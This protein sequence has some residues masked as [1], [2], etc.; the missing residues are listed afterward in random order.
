M[1]FTQASAKAGFIQMLKHLWKFF[2]SIPCWIKSQEPQGIGTLLVGIA[3]LWAL[4][5]G[6]SILDR[7][8]K[9]Q[10]QATEISGAVSE[11]KLQ[12]AKISSAVEMMEAQLKALRASQEVASSAVLKSSGSSKEQISEALASIPSAPSEHRPTVYLPIKKRNATVELL[13]RA[14]TPEQRQMIL[15]DSLEYKGPQALATEGGDA[16]T[17]EQGEKLIYEDAPANGQKK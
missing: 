4:K 2:K 1:A 14:R 10:E 9:I 8:L 16:L 3:A 15:Q 6:S 11:L 12:S 7:I 17:T 13:Y 5:D